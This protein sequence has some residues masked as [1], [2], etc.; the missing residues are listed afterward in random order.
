MLRRLL[1]LLPLLAACTS[2]TGPELTANRRALA[3]VRK[4][5]R[6][7]YTWNEQLR[8]FVLT[9]VEGNCSGQP[10]PD[11]CSVPGSSAGCGSGGGG[12]GGW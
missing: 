4:D 10:G 7:V 9:A 6:Y 8:K 2:P 3:R 11:P 5:C 1:L 12:G